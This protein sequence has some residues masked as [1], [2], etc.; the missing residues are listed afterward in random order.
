MLLFEEK[1]VPTGP[2]ELAFLETSHHLVKV[3]TSYYLR[4]PRQGAMTPGLCQ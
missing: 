2:L 4:F 3:D 1:Q